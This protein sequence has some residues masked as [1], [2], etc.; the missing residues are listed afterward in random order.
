M[1]QRP[2]HGPD[3]GA[4]PRL[5]PVRAATLGGTFFARLPVK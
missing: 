5:L 2:A 4:F 3:F 1:V